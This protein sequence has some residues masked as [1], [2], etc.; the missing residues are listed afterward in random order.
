MLF[1]SGA[2]APETP[3]ARA[4][5]K[6]ASAPACSTPPADEE[7]PPPSDGDATPVRFIACHF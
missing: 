4:Q 5:D 2:K 1:V 3:S 7:P 6:R